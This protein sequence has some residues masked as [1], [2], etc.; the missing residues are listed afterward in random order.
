MEAKQRIRKAIYISL[1]I[2]LIEAALL[3]IFQD[4][5]F[6]LLVAVNFVIGWSYLFLVS[7]HGDIAEELWHYFDK[8]AQYTKLQS[9]LFVIYEFKR[10]IYTRTGKIMKLMEKREIVDEFILERVRE[11]DILREIG[12]VLIFVPSS[13]LFLGCY[14][15]MAI[16]AGLF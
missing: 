10:S 13:I 15:F 3:I 8:R 11:L 2:G 6:M 16:D 4:S 12:A 9:E 1:V 5:Y 7:R 14:V